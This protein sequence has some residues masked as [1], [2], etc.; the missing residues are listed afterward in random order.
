MKR[1][2]C[3]SCKLAW[4]E[5]AEPVM[6]DACYTVGRPKPPENL[7]MQTPGGPRRLNLA[8]RSA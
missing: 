5:H 2:I 8:P 4:A 6:C 1:R 3:T 7:G